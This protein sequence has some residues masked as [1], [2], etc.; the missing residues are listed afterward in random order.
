[1]V[2]SG[3][4]PTLDGLLLEASQTAAIQIASGSR[5]RIRG[6][7]ISGGEVGIMVTD[8]APVIGGNDV[9][10]TGSAGVQVDGGAAKLTGNSIHDNQGSGVSV[11]RGTATLA[12][13]TII[14]NGT[15]LLLG[16]HADPT[17][18]HNVICG[19]ATEVEPL[20][21]AELPDAIA[22]QVCPS[23]ALEERP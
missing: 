23:E 7:T 13:N 4:A 8:S 6:N 21:G 22:D 2:I 19:N 3:G 20:D 1:M 18:L 9:A 14:G 11:L 5:A 12:D 17:L 15:G 10:G 16:T